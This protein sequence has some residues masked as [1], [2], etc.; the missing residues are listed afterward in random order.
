MQQFNLYIMVFVRG[1]HECFD[2]LA[3]CLVSSGMYSEARISLR[4]LALDSCIIGF[5]RGWNSF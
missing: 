3:G 1:L 5:V 4:E 2:S